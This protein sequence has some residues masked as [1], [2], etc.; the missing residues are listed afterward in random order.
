MDPPRGLGSLILAHNA[1]CVALGAR[2]VLA[3]PPATMAWEFP[4]W[5]GPNHNEDSGL[6]RYILCAVKNSTSAGLGFI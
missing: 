1:A 3:A 6:L 2:Q 4:C 5:V